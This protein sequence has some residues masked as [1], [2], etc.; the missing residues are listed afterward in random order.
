MDQAA[1]CF[2]NYWAMN[3]PFLMSCRGMP[4]TMLYVGEGAF[5]D[6]GGLQDFAF[7]SFPEDFYEFSQLSYTHAR[8]RTPTPTLCHVHTRL[9]LSFLYGL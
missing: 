6:G 4:E 1:V 3:E 9:R 5:M 2:D 7:V 8:T